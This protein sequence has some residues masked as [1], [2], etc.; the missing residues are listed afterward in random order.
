MTV[1]FQRLSQPQNPASK[2]IS[3]HAVTHLGQLP[4]RKLSK[5]TAGLSKLSK[6]PRF[7]GLLGSS[8]GKHQP[9]P[10]L[11]KHILYIL[12]EFILFRSKQTVELYLNSDHEDRTK[13][14]YD[15]CLEVTEA[16]PKDRL[17][18]KE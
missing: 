18:S 8:M 16:E 4:L 13:E 3:R 15:T 5:M 7:G 11:H 17:L 1:L 9:V 12:Q 10:C 6:P 2:P 14:N